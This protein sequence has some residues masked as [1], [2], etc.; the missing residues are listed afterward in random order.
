MALQEMVNREKSGS[1]CTDEV[2]R[3]WDIKQEYHQSSD[4]ESPFIWGE[5]FD[6]A[7]A[8][9]TYANMCRSASIPT[10]IRSCHY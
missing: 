1:T 8:W 7:A 3:V 2:E 10:S 6:G 5:T 4:G 9:V